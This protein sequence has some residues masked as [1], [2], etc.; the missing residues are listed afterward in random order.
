MTFNLEPLHSLTDGFVYQHE[1]LLES[2]MSIVVVVLMG[3]QNN[4]RLNRGHVIT[5]TLVEGVD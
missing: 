4:V 2:I 5:D 1:S 3:F